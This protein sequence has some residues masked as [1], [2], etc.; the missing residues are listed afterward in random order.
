MDVNTHFKVV[1]VTIQH[2]SVNSN[3]YGSSVQKRLY[4][5]KQETGD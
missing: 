3:L 5:Y 2:T 1:T 4:K